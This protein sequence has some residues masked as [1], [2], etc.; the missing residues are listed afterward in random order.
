MDRSTLR[1]MI[2]AIGEL[3]TMPEEVP[4]AHEHAFV[5]E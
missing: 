3:I 5:V 1:P 4:V 2:T